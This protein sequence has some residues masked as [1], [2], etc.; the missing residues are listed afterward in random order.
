VLHLAYRNGLDLPLLKSLLPSNDAHLKRAIDM[1]PDN[2]MRRIGLNGLAFKAGTDDL[3]ESPI[4]LIAEHL[5]GK[6][7]DLKIHDEGIE[8]SRITGANR[9]YIEKR[10]PHLSSRLVST[11]DELVEQ[12]EIIL[13]TRDGD[14]VTDRAAKLGKRP[15]V[16]DLSG[17]VPQSKKTAPVVIISR[18]PEA[19]KKRDMK[20]MPA[21]NGRYRQTNKTNGKAGRQLAAAV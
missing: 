4:V 15:L 7:F 19:V 12:S 13:V 5:L 1:I 21:L 16:I 20:L 8:T 6:G 3:R 17:R 10:I 2:G 11:L 18:P 14:A 9:E